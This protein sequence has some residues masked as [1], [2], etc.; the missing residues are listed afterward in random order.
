MGCFLTSI[1]TG[2]WEMLRLTRFDSRIN[3]QSEI[4]LSTEK[5]TTKCR[6]RFLFVNAKF[7]FYSSLFINRK[8][9]KTKR[10]FLFKNF[11]LFSPPHFAI[12]RK[13]STVENLKKQNKKAIFNRDDMINFSSNVPRI[14]L[15]IDVRAFWM[16][17]YDPRMWILLEIKTHKSQWTDLGLF[18]IVYSS[19]K[20]IR[21]RV[22]FSMAY[23]VRPFLPAIRPIARDKWSPFKGFTRID[24]QQN[25]KGIRQTLLLWLITIVYFKRFEKQVVQTN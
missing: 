22:A 3:V 9:K 12:F 17:W 24:K 10:V 6:E 13:L 18:R 4:F 1:N 20:T 15:Q 8:N 19:A 14:K 16:F 21:H 5:K 23:F 25:K 2:D 11:L 7:D